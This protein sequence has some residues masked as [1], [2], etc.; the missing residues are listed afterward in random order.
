MDELIPILLIAGVVLVILFYAAW[1]ALAAL[2]HVLAWLL[3]YWGAGTAVMLLIGVAVSLVLPLRVLSS[4][5]SCKPMI[6]TPAEV[7]AGRVAGATPRGSSKFFGWDHG[8]PLYLPYQAKRDAAAVLAEARHV[9]GVVAGRASQLRL[10]S[11][12]G[13]GGTESWTAL[14]TVARMKVTAPNVVWGVVMLPLV[15]FAIGLWVSIL[16]WCV[17]MALFGGA[18]GSVQQLGILAYRWQDRALRRWRRATLRCTNCY[19]ISRMPSYECSDPSCSVVH[20]DVSPGVLGVVRRRCVCGTSLTLTV[21]GAASSLDT[22]CPHCSKPLPKASGT[23]RVV[24]LP[25]IGSVGAGKTQFLAGGVVG[26]ERRLRVVSGELTPISRIAEQFMTSARA[27]VTTGRGTDKTPWKDQPEGMPLLLST[28]GKTVELQLMDAAGESFVD[29]ER[30][31]SLGYLDSS[32]VLL[33]MLDP[34]ALPEV[35]ALLR[36]SGMEGTVQVAQGDPEDA[37]ANVVD[38][39][40]SEKVKLRGKRLGVVVTKVDHLMRLPGA[41]EVCAG[42]TEG[43]RSWLGDNGADGLIRRVDRDF[44]DVTYFAVDS[45]GRRDVLDDLHP[46]QVF[47]WVLRTCGARLSLLPPRSA[48]VPVTPEEQPV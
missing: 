6:A 40:R 9:T 20:R 44:K 14:R 1:T 47:D 31:R 36:A 45:L 18:V 8:W 7:V 41:Y 39:L 17:V 28:G 27:L 48:A 26:I 21:R 25:V 5:A 3:V 24:V 11:M 4:R 29:W 42:D 46:I 32:D 10:G 30:T 16:T 23:R 33:F 2:A 43:L 34:F 13:L 12:A 37:Y 15:G 38:R 35:S 22:V 19:R